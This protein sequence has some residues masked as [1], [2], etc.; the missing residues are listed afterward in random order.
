[1]RF[2]KKLYYKIIYRK[3]EQKYRLDIIDKLDN[4]KVI[5]SR[6]IIFYELYTY[7]DF[8]PKNDVAVYI[9]RVK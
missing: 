9:E 1:M 5:S 7:L 4:N 2:L 3:K 8:L 6:I